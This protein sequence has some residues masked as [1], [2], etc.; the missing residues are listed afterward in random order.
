MEQNQPKWPGVAA[1]VG[2][3][4]LYCV[5]CALKRYGPGIQDLVEDRDT[6]GELLDDEGNPLGVVLRFSED[7]HAQYCGACHTRLCDEDCCCYQTEV[8]WESQQDDEGESE[9]AEE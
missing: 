2:D 6:A 3:A 9:E 1:I 8:A 5:S 4:D 7:L